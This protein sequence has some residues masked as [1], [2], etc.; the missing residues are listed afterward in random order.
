MRKMIGIALLIA[1]A[2]LS[3]TA[4]L[5]CGD[6]LLAIG[7]GV[8]FQRISAAHEANLLIYS[9]GTERRAV[10][11][12]NNVQTALRRSVR[13]LQL[14]QDGSE[15]DEALKSGRVDVVLVDFADLAG[16][17]RQL[18]SAPSKPVIVPILVKPSKA[19]LA[20]A[21]REYKFALKA[22]TDASDYLIAIDEAMKLRARTGAKS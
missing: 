14:V 16:I 4:A 3:G 1:I 22:S 12:N 15:L 10:L 6:K 7:R 5:A 13:K 11:G 2:L 19:E 21:Q 17:T 9:A 20:A 8:R 18:Q